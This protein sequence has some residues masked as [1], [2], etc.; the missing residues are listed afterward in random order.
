[1]AAVEGVPALYRY[2]FL[3][4]DPLIAGSSVYMDVFTPAFILDVY[5]PSVRYDPG[6]Q[7]R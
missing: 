7:V 1:M 5:N 3:Y 2:W 4:A 6:Y